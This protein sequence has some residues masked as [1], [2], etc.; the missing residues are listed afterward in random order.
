M[1]PKSLVTQNDIIF[2]SFKNF[3]F[4]PQ[5]FIL[6]S[7]T[8]DMHIFVSAGN[9]ILCD[10]YFFSPLFTFCFLSLLSYG[11]ILYYLKLLQHIPCQTWPTHFSSCVSCTN[12]GM[13]ETSK[14]S[15]QEYYQLVQHLLLQNVFI[16]K[17][18]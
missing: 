12:A 10:K 18:Q 16:C 15:V 11:R 5:Q 1:F 9:S 4:R 6:P 14:H 3:R 13:P 7:Q 8:F 17:L 2:F